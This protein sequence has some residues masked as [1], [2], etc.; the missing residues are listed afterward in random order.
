LMVTPQIAAD[1]IIHMHVVPSVA[2]G[3][4]TAAAGTSAHRFEASVDTLMRLA[5]GDTV[6][7]AGLLRSRDGASYA[8]LVLLLTAT[9]VTPAT[10]LAGGGR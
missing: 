10:P 5:D 8:E 6:V 3:P 9:T 7:I 1:G 2:D 4:A